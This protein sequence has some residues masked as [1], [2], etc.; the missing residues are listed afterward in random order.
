MIQRTTAVHAHLHGVR[1]RPFLLEENFVISRG[2]ADSAAVRDR[3][4]KLTELW[5]KGITRRPPIWEAQGRDR[6]RGGVRGA[7]GC[8]FQPGVRIS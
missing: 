5:A 7:E 1:T 4:A 2:I 8:S 6:R 3:S